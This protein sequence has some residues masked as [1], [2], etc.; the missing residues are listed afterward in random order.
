MFRQK[1]LLFVLLAINFSAK[2]Q[3]VS[4]ARAWLDT[5]CSSS[6]HGRGY[7]FEGDKKAAD[8]LSQ[9]LKKISLKP[10]KSSFLQPFQISVNTFE[11]KMNLMLNTEKL[12]AG[13]DFLVTANSKNIFGKFKVKRFDKN[14]YK[15]I[16]ELK[17]RN[18]SKIFL[19]LDTSGIN[20]K[21]EAEKL[22]AYKKNPFS[23]AGVIE[24]CNKLPAYVPSSTVSNFITIQILRSKIPKNLKSLY[25]EIENRFHS[26]YTTQ[27]VAGYVQGEIDSFVVFTAHYDHLG[28]M[29]EQVYFAG[30]NDNASGVVL[31]MDLAQ[32]F[33]QNK[34]KYSVA[35]LFFS[36]EELGIIGSSYYNQNPL[37]PLSKIKFLT[38]L[39][40]VGSGEEGIKVVNATVFKREFELLQ[41]INNH[42]NS[43]SQIGSRAPA[44]NS[45]HYFFYQNHVPCFF[46]YTLGKYA[47]YHNINDKPAN[48]PFH[49]YNELFHLLVNFT[50]QL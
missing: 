10:F 42:D 36:A 43:F 32:Y 13:V 18:N 14:N 25:L 9:H 50:N 21:Q 12:S 39:D 31:L 28:R 15:K 22:M 45:D 46:I 23:A 7:A 40:M 47:E 27:N 3:D 16:D 37:F 17:N 33:S 4:Q 26:A 2:T 41:K 19:I 20:N 34:P 38:N 5:L 11:G 30:A 44:A 1:I 8:F 24:V 29:G 6:Y 49:K 48:L 35:F